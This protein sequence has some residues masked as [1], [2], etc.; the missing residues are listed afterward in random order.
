MLFFYA[1]VNN[2]HILLKS[3]IILSMPTIPRIRNVFVQ[4]QREFSEPIVPESF[5]DIAKNTKITH[6]IYGSELWY[7]SNNEGLLLLT[8][9]FSLEII[10][11]AYPIAIRANP[12]YNYLNSQCTLNS[13]TSYDNKRR[14]H[15][16]RLNEI[17]SHRY[18]F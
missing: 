18:Y 11:Y 5:R 1:Q 4:S 7:R 16:L 14:G 10:A 2:L 6:Y 13:S 12:S 17:N 3:P 15:A 9:A 8:S